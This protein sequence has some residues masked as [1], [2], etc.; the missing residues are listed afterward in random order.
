MQTPPRP[1]LTDA[2][3]RAVAEAMADIMIAH[4]HITAGKVGLTPD[5]LARLPDD[6]VAAFRP[7]M[8]GAALAAALQAERGW[9]FVNTTIVMLLESFNASVYDALADVQRKWVADNAITARFK[10]GAHVIWSGQPGTIT[11]IDP[12]WPATYLMRLDGDG[13]PPNLRRTVHVP[14]EAVEPATD[15]VAA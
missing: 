12:V 13:L 3:T 7:G 9:H 8:D 15:Q 10:P 4:G 2:I 11:S 5:R 14:F 1:T 6:I